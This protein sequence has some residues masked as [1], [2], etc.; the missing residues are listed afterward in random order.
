MSLIVAFFQGER[1][2]PAKN[3]TFNKK[4]EP[5]FHKNEAP[6]RSF[7]NRYCSWID[8][9]YIRSAYSATMRRMENSG[10]SVRIAFLTIVIQP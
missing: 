4:S 9:I 10:E 1:F 2:R 6:T 8:G 3:Q 7:G 5:H